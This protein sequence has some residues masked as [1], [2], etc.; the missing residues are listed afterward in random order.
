MLRGILGEL[1]HHVTDRG[2]AD[3][4]HPLVAPG[5][6]HV[7]I[8]ESKHLPWPRDRPAFRVQRGK[9]MRGTLMYQRT[10][11]VE[12]EFSLLLRD[13]MAVPNLVVHGLRGHHLISP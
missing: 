4:I 11:D 3:A 8:V 9:R 6:G 10:V 13:H 12:Q 5:G 1:E 2:G 7:V